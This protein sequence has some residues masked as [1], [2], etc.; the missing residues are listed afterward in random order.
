MLVS[1]T[2]LRRLLL[3][4][5]LSGASLVAAQAQTGVTIG[6][7]TAPD[8]SA[9]LDIISTSKGVL[10]PRV[11]SAAAIASP[12]TGLIVFQTGAPAG[13]YYYVGGAW[14]QLATAAGAAVTAG[15][16]LTKTGQNLTL[17]G[18]LTTPA[19]ILQGG[20]NFSLSGGNVGI[21]TGAPAARL[22]VA[23]DLSVTVPAVTS[24]YSIDQN[25]TTSNIGTAAVGQSFTTLAAGR[26]TTVTVY[27]VGN[28]NATFSLY[29]GVGGSRA[30]LTRQA[31]SLPATG[32]FVITLNSPQTVGAGAVLMFEFDNAGMFGVY[33]QNAPNVYA[34]GAAYINGAASGTTDFR[35][36][37]GVDTSTPAGQTL[38]AATSGNVGIGTLTP[39]Q[40]LE[41]AGGIKFTGAGNVL[42]FPDGSTQATAAAPANLTGDITSTG[43]A[44]TYAGIVPATKGGAGTVSGLL[45]A[46]GSGTVSAATA[47]TDYLTPT[48]ANAAYVQNT[49]SPQ[50]GANFNVSGNGTV[51][52]NSTVGGT[53]TV[54]GL[55]T[56]NGGATLTGPLEVF[57]PGTTGTAVV[58][59]DN[60]SGTFLLR[61]DPSPF[62]QSFTA[63][64]AGKL[65]Q[66]AV[67]CDGYNPSFGGMAGQALLEVFA[68]N[69]PSGAALASQLFAL[70]AATGSRPPLTLITFLAPA[71]VT[72]GN[73]YCF[74][75]SLV[76]GASLIGNY[77]CITNCYAGGASDVN[78]DW[79]SQFRT[80]VAPIIPPASTL[81]VT[82]G[83]VGIGTPAPSQKLEV[84]GGIKFTGTGNVLTFPDG[85]TQATATLTGPAGATGP[86]GP[87]GT[88]G[89]TG[90]TGTTGATGPQ[91]PAG[92]TG[93]QGTTGPAGPTG[94]QG[95]AGTAG[96]NGTADNLGNHTAT[97][98]LNLTNKLLV[99][100]TAASPG[101]SGLAVD[102]SGNVAIG[103][104]STATGAVQ[105]GTT[106]AVDA[107]N[108][109]TGT[110][111]NFL[112]FGATG[113]GEGIGSKRS[114]GGNQS[115]LDFYT[116]FTNRLSI[117]NGGNVGI[118]TPTP[119]VVLDVASG[120]GTQLNLTNTSGDPN[121][122]ITMTIP[123]SGACNTCGELIIFSKAGGTQL[124]NIGSNL[125]GNAVTYN[126]TS[127]K[128]LK[129][130]I[131]RTRFGLADLLKLEVKDY[132]FI[133]QPASSRV[134]G[135]LAQDL[136]KVYPDAVK[137][138]DYGPT[139]T[140][141]WAVD[142]GRITPLLVQ[143]IQDQQTLIDKQQAEL[144]A[145]KT[146]NAAL[147]TG[148]AAD[149]ASLLTLQAQMARLL[150]EGAQAAK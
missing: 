97:Q 22:E 5:G 56:G 105:A 1:V 98:N 20:N 79:D 132:N 99:G 81:L 136:F 31:V 119:G 114:S 109:N 144:N 48:G 88:T 86:A 42:T 148:S 51:G 64:A 36:A 104:N 113:S 90:S 82:G 122:V 39:S 61:S 24:G 40:K 74:R 130:H 124:G 35:F 147:Q 3:V 63:G 38:Y 75:V 102:A 4:L 72:A 11:A 65:Q 52:G 23:G 92:A 67:T 13:F 18:S 28:S 7:T 53:S 85:S 125:S 95:A 143:A 19:T 44:T 8:A 10:L 80:F 34:G 46:D 54:A 21:G 138:G 57:R 149:H 140:N 55:L 70:S 25:T 68:G 9:A 133:G 83:N 135:F 150:G 73:R 146:Q 27:P 145:L 118:G 112:R 91:G 77:L 100:G 29:R 117:T 131:G 66:L 142:Y 128:R 123:A 30:L 94:P 33:L 87:Q 16:G 37:V 14:Q 43:A 137:E 126:T 96:T 17:G 32:P 121:G 84:A 120:G 103:G 47:G 69:T 12:A 115:G 2:S 108:G 116:S 129:E 59:Q 6:A 45:K 26:V 62:S 76:S 127:D 139:V 111:A 49:T 134:T 89:A 141:Q 60:S 101:T 71:T 78:P 110:A 107:A 50:A 106:V 15:N 58:D 41:V 93:T